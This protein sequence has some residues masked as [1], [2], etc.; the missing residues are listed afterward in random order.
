MELIRVLFFDSKILELNNRFKHKS[1]ATYQVT[2]KTCHM[3]RTVSCLGFMAVDHVVVIPEKRHHSCHSLT[4]IFSDGLEEDSLP[5][6]AVARKCLVQEDWPRRQ[7][8]VAGQRLHVNLQETHWGE[9][10]WNQDQC[11]LLHILKW[12]IHLLKYR[13]NAGDITLS[14]A[15]KSV[16]Y[17]KKIQCNKV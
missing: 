5:G 16:I 10:T 17:S 4:F 7:A 12:T 8:A 6:G 15:I 14:E 11:K 9:K 1:A 13:S 2:E 3:Q